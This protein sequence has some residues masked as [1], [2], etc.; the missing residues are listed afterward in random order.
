MKRQVQLRRAKTSRENLS[1]FGKRT[2]KHASASAK[3]SGSPV[4][5]TEPTAH[6]I[7]SNCTVQPRALPITTS[8]SETTS[9]APSICHCQVPGG[10]LREDAMTRTLLS[11]HLWK[12]AR[13]FSGDT[14]TLFWLA[15]QT[16]FDHA[17]RCAK[18][19]KFKL[20][21]PI[22]RMKR[23]FNSARHSFFLQLASRRLE[24]TK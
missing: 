6:P 14:V 8:V 19:F 5:L 24:R 1:P 17:A 22:S 12:R 3:T 2:S 21:K 4:M 7:K 13:T 10:S 11:F 9:T 15:N 23:V 20:P 18:A 16:S